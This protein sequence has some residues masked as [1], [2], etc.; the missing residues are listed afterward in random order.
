[1]DIGLTRVGTQ[2]A[3]VNKDHASWVAFRSCQGSSFYARAL[4]LPPFVVQIIN[5][6]VSFESL[7]SRLSRLNQE[8]TQSRGGKFVAAACPFIKKAIEVFR[9]IL[10][11][12]YGY[13]RILHEFPNKG[14]SEARVMS[15]DKAEISVR[16]TSENQIRIKI[17]I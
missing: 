2:R 5:S 11:E 14:N 16:N 17:K 10:E 9:V 12:H 13:L 3:Q 7:P 4:P 6:P 1:V 15:G 8:T